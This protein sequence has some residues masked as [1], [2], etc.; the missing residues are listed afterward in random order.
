[1]EKSNAAPLFLAGAVALAGLFVGMGFERG[2]RAEPFVEVKGLAERAVTADVALWPLRYSAAANELSTAQQ[3]LSRSTSEVLAF[4]ARHGLDSNSVQVR[5]LDVFDA[6]ANRY[7]TNRDGPRFIIQQT[8]MV[9]SNSPDVVLAASQ[10]VGELV[11]AGVVLS[12]GGEYGISGGPTFL[13]TR[14]NELK[15]EMIAEA[16]ANAREAAEQFARDS[17]TSLGKIRFA[18]Q[19]LFVILARD[20]APGVN[21]ANQIEKTVRVVSTVQYLLR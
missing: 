2:R 12:S 17:R 4:L 21:E 16:T 18:N 3:A 19:G 8:V 1:M 11:T 6:N 5:E 15:P 9:R 7:Q 20:P 14:L 10:K 13:F